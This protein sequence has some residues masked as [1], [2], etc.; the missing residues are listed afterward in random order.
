MSNAKHGLSLLG[1]MRE[2]NSGEPNSP[3]LYAVSGLPSTDNCIIGYARGNDGRS[4]WY[5]HW[6]RSGN[7]VPVPEGPYDS[8]EEALNIAASLHSEVI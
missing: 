2:V 6:Y 5:L 4:K 7:Q 8:P 1:W 3:I